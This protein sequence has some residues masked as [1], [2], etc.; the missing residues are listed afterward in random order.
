MMVN[1]KTW[2]GV[3]A[4]LLIVILWIIHHVRRR[5]LAVRRANLERL[6]QHVHSL[7]DVVGGLP[8][9]SA[10][11]QH[12][13][14]SEITREMLILAAFH[15]RELHPVIVALVGQ[16]NIC[17]NEASIASRYHSQPALAHSAPR[18]VGRGYW[19]KQ[20]FEGHADAAASK[21]RAL[22]G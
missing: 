16:A 6:L 19:N 4:L 11:N 7:R 13:K 2:I 20:S 22:L 15:L 3:S 14:V 1:V 21:V 12:V 18:L 8:G 9:S 17:V 10:S 5:R